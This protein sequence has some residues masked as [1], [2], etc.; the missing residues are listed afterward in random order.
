MLSMNWCRCDHDDNWCELFEVTLPAASWF[1]PVSGVFVIWQGGTRPR[2]ITV[3]QGDIR[4]QLL[5]CRQDPRILA[6]RDPGP[7]YV[8]WDT[9]ARPMQSGVH[10]YLA[11]T[12]A[13]LLPGPQADVE[14][15]QV[16]L[17]LIAMKVKSPSDA[18][19]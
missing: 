10:R 12:T 14:P 5:A 9:L 7:I 19:P 13:P 18:P 6:Y 4:K 11:E 8:T 16:T 3:G 2:V 17:P 15:I 1:R